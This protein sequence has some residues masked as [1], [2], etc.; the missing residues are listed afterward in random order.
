MQ[1]MPQPDAGFEKIFT[2]LRPTIRFPAALPSLILLLQPLHQGGE[3]FDDRPGIHLPRTR[4]LLQGFLPGTAGPQGQHRHESLARLPVTV[5][6]AFVQGTLPAGGRTQGLVELELQEE[7][8]KIARIRGIPGDVV[9][10]SGVE[11]RL[12][13]FYRG[14]NTLVSGTQLPPALVIAFRR[15]TA[16]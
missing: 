7:G 3:I 8:E 4:Q 10:G 14:D 9:L 5:D 2:S 12:A 16:V 1:A 13:A 11:I 6:R 15:D